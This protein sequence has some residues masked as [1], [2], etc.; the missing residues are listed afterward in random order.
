MLRRGCC[1][2]SDL[3]G[4]LRAFQAWRE[5]KASGPT[6]RQEAEWCWSNFLSLSVLHDVEEMRIQIRTSLAQVTECDPITEQELADLRFQ[7]QAHRELGNHW[8]WTRHDGNDFRG[9]LPPW[10]SQRLCLVRW[11]IALAFASNAVGVG[12]TPC[13]DVM[14]T[15]RRRTSKHALQQFLTRHLQLQGVQEPRESNRPG[16]FFVR[17]GDVRQAQQA[18]QM[19]SMAVRFD[20]PFSREPRLA[21]DNKVKLYCAEDQFRLMGASR[22]RLTSDSVCAPAVSL[23]STVVAALVMLVEEKSGDDLFVC[24]H[25]TELP[26][27]LLPAVLAARPSSSFDTSTFEVRASLRGVT[28]CLQLDD[29]LAEKAELVRTC[30]LS[31][32]KLT[33]ATREA[34]RQA[35]LDLMESAHGLEREQ[36]ADTSAFNN[37]TFPLAAAS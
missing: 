5:Y 12:G 9:R 11:C 24:K 35:V 36:R 13:R 4:G 22:T 17:F 33:G 29:R 34:A 6:A 30:H 14:F 8:S 10:D 1:R 3:L 18:V 20:C 23:P 15:C 25:L 27:A 19:G 31:D 21:Q 26:N 28:R 32:S 7:R 37:A 16:R 2:D